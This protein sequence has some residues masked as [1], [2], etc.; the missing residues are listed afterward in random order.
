[1]IGGIK[2]DSIDGVLAA[3]KDQ[4]RD[5]FGVAF[6]NSAGQGGTVIVGGVGDADEKIDTFQVSIVRGGDQGWGVFGPFRVGEGNEHPDT[7]SMASRGRCMNGGC[8]IKFLLVAAGQEKAGEAS[9]I[10]SLGTA[11]QGMLFDQ[12]FRRPWRLLRLFA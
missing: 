1:M 6:P 8:G 12:E 5:T 10:V 2:N 7:F 4:D 9:A 3:D 11:R